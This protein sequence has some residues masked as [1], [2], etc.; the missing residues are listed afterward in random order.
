MT[1]DEIGQRQRLP[2]E[3]VAAIARECK[4]LR[5]L[6]RWTIGSS[7]AF[8]FALFAMPD[9]AQVFLMPCLALWLY[10]ASITRTRTAAR[11]A[12]WEPVDRVR[13]FARGGS[14]RSRSVFVELSDGR[15]QLL[16]RGMRPVTLSSYEG[17]ALRGQTGGRTLLLVPG[18]RG[19]YH[20]V[21]DPLPWLR[22]PGMT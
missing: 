3:V 14:L 13:I 1:S 22:P 20:V 10:F 2:D 12:T 8:L 5:I 9:A 16:T 11:K 21:N 4:T 18:S 7:A 15:T 19:L 6:V 17:P